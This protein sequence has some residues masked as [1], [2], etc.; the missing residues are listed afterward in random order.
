M[1]PISA[2]L[3]IIFGAFV[4]HWLMATLQLRNLKRL[5]DLRDDLWLAYRYRWRKGGER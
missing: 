5:D 3:I 2:A 1:I 4:Y